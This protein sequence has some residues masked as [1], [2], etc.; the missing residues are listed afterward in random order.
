MLKLSLTFRFYP[1]G[2]QFI[3]A[4][5]HAPCVGV[6]VLDEDACEVVNNA[7]YINDLFATFTTSIE[8]IS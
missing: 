6:L 5:Y 3:R 7:V 8:F 2:T 4:K 1:C